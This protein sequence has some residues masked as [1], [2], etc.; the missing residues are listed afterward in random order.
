VMRGLGLGDQIGRREMG[1]CCW[2]G[3]RVAWRTVAT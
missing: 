1:R 3:A 2:L